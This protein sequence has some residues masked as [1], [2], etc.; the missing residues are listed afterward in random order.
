MAIS[1]Q[2]AR[3]GALPEL[4]EQEQQ[5]LEDIERQIDK[6]LVSVFGREVKPNEQILSTSVAIKN[7][8]K[9]ELTP[10]IFANLEAR[11]KALGWGRVSLLESPTNKPPAHYYS[12]QINV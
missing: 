3:S 2:R 5:R 12:V 4:S 11:Y 10:A 7:C 6:Q 9:G 8:P 1:P